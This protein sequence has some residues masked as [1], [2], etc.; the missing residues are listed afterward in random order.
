MSVDPRIKQALREEDVRFRIMADCAPVALWMA[1]LDAKCTFFNQ[2]WLDFTGRSMEEELG[3]GWAEGVHALDFQRC[4]DTY[5]TA[6]NARR[7]FKMEYRLRR[8]DGEYRWILD[9][10]TPYFTADH[11]FA[12]YIGS[13]VDITERKH[14]EDAAREMN[15]VLERRVADRTTELQKAN[16]S[17]EA[18]SYSVS[19]DLRAPLRHVQ[20]F[21]HLLERDAGDRVGEKAKEYLHLIADAAKRM[22]RLIDELLEF[23]RMGRVELSQSRVNMEDLVRDV[24][25]FTA[26]D[27]GQRTVVWEIG[28]LPAVHGDP[29][30]LRLVVE[31]LISNALK[32]SRYRSETR[33]AIGSS[34]AEN[35]KSVFFVRDNG[36]GFDPQYAGKL[37]G[38]FQR[39]HSSEEYE[40]TGIGLANVQRVIERHGGKV[41][42]E[43]ILNQGATFYFSLNEA[44]EEP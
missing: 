20:G 40:G 26:G 1:G 42:A 19:H 17:L 32:Y 35:G 41:W 12:G 14:A 7:P 4:V 37:F 38:V 27:I 25:Q 39:L 13:C 36:V 6:F 33:I 24:V 2:F 18:F 8:H 3:D 30:M 21:I 22:G 9:H 31:N 44:R 5:L 16:E 34:P 23:S 15:E 11:R 29:S 43:A 10:G 28:P